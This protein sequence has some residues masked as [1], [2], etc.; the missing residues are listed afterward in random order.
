MKIND[1]IFNL[2][3]N[4]LNIG[5]LDIYRFLFLFTK[6]TKYA[7]KN[8]LEVFAKEELEKTFRTGCDILI[9]ELSNKSYEAKLTKVSYSK[10]IDKLYFF[11]QGQ[12][13]YVDKFSAI[14]YDDFFKVL[15]TSYLK[16]FSNCFDERVKHINEYK[17][18]KNICL[19]KVKNKIKNIID[20][21]P[22]NFSMNNLVYSL[23]KLTNTSYYSMSLSKNEVKCF[24][25]PSRNEFCENFEVS[26]IEIEVSDGVLV[27]KIIILDKKNNKKYELSNTLDYWNGEFYSNPR[28][29]STI[30]KDLIHN[31][32][33]KK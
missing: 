15:P 20:N 23:L 18:E 25:I 13:F 4:S 12:E 2:N 26:S 28:L 3:L 16:V 32:Y 6:S 7:N 27:I 29:K 19:A 31:I 33:T 14:S 21:K 10:S 17:K 24:L 9:T 8:I 5:N 1:N 30:D 22:E 11:Y